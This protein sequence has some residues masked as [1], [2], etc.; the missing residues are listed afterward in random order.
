MVTQ[1]YSYIYIIDRKIYIYTVT[2][3]ATQKYRTQQDNFLGQYSLK[4]Y[5]DLAYVRYLQFRFLTD[6]LTDYRFLFLPEL[7]HHL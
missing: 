3:T 5:L 7:S 1:S 6:P 2:S 4:P